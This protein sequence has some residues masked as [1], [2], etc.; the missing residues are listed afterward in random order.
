MDDGRRRIARAPVREVPAPRRCSAR[1]RAGSGCGNGS[2]RAAPSAT[3]ARRSAR[4][5]PGARPGR[6]PGSPRSAARYRDARGRANSCS[7]GPT[8]HSRPRYIT[9]TRSLTAFTTARSWA[10]NRQRQAEAR[11][12]VLQQIEDLRADRNVER[13]DR[14]VADDEFRIEHQRPRDADAL[15]LPAGEF[16]RQPTDATSWGSRPTAPSTSWTSCS[17]LP[18]I[19]DAGD[20][21]RLGDD[22]AD[23]PPRD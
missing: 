7:D 23:P 13:R 22:V 6:A 2:P 14:L 16:M 18:R 17:R 15:A 1:R 8:S 20:Q 19:L 5:R 4:S 9:A 10:M 21:Q 11:L 12:H 3:A